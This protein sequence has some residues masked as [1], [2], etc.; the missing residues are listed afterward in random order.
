MSDR[1]KIEAIKRLLASGE[2]SDESLEPTPIEW[3]FDYYTRKGYYFYTDYDMNYRTGEET[4][5]IYA[6]QEKNDMRSCMDADSVTKWNIR[7]FMQ[8]I[9]GLIEQD[10]RS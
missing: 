7:M 9:A 3:L 8:C 4:E 10:L 1:E 2:D 6:Y 5:R